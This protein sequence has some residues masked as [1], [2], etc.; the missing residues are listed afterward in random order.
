MKWPPTNNRCVFVVHGTSVAVAV[1]VFDVAVAVVV[2]AVAV[3][4]SKEERSCIGK[5]GT[6]YM[7]LVGDKDVHRPVLVAA[8]VFVA[9]EFSVAVEFSVAGFSVAEEEG[10]TKADVVDIVDTAS[11]IRPYC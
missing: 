1:V 11:Y 4:A 5:G 8:A 7:D 9:A 2:V 10:M 3:A 6:E